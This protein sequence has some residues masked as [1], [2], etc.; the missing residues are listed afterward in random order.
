MT[1]ARMFEGA[2]GLYRHGRDEGARGL[3]GR[4]GER[5]RGLGKR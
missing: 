3:I 1:E 5:G 4:G 2:G